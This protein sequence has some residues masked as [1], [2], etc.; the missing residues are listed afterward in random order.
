MSEAWPFAELPPEER[1]QLQA[2][3]RELAKRPEAAR[4]EDL[5]VLIIHSRGQTFAV[6]LLSVLS[7]AELH[8]LALIP[9]GPAAVRGLVSVRGE[10]IVAVELAALAGGGQA[11]LSDLRRVV[12]VASGPRRL[13]ILTE[14]MLSV[15]A[16]AASV[17]ARDPLA[18]HPAIAGTDAELTSLVDPDALVTEAFRQLEQAR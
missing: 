5:E 7:V 2:A 13:A 9:R 18:A 17:F 1:A 16:T 15:R 3:A 12:V 11:G 4:Q 6:P 14:R 10:V 8:S